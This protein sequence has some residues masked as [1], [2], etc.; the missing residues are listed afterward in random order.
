MIGRAL[1][2]LTLAACSA[3]HPLDRDVAF[4]GAPVTAGSVEEVPVKGF[5][6]TVF[7][8]AGSKPVRQV[9]GELLAADASGVDLREY[10]ES[11]TNVHVAADDIDYVEIVLVDRKIY[12]MILAVWGVGGTVSTLSHGFFLLFSAPSWAAVTVPTSISAGWP[13]VTEARVGNLARLAQYARFPQGLPG[14]WR[15]VKP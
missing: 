6:A 10:D 11:T 4:G 3:Q 15:T 12:S 14:S 8:R 13:S 9:T 7:P 5:E 1:L 2:L